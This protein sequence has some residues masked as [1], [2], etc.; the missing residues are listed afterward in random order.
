MDDFKLKGNKNPKIKSTYDD[1]ILKFRLD[2]EDLAEPDEFEYF[3]KSVEK[4]VRTDPRYKNYLNQLH[5]EGWQIR[6]D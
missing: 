2:K 1:T 3:I 5:D 6:Y 4:M